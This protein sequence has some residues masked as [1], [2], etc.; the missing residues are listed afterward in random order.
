MPCLTG[1]SAVGH[2]LE[3]SKVMFLPQSD[4]PDT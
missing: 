2:F 1:W 4:P 3:L